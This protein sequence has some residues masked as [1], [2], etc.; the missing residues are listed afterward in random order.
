[1]RKTSKTE[2]RLC[3]RL[4]S[5]LEKL[6]ANSVIEDSEEFYWVLVSLNFFLPEV[7]VEIHPEW[8]YESLDDIYPEMARK[9]GEN[10]IEIIGICCFISDQTLTPLHLQLQIDPDRNMVSWLECWLGE[11]TEDGLFRVPYDTSTV[12]GKKLNVLNRLDSIKWFYHVGY[13]ER[14]R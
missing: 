14:R 11:D 8:R 13:G 1:M 12:V 10:E 3:I 9:V 5:F 7:F 6:A 4:R 2:E